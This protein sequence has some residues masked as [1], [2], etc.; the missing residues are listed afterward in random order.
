MWGVFFS[1]GRQAVLQTQTC[2]DR[3]PK[4]HNRFPHAWLRDRNRHPP[5]R[6]GGPIGPISVDLPQ[7]RAAIERN[8]YGIQASED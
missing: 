1:S 7:P 4:H 8:T 6:P 3:D 5:G 2:T